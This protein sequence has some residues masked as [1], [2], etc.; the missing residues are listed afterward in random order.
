MCEVRRFDTLN[1]QHESVRVFETQDAAVG[2]CASDLYRY[3][4]SAEGTFRYLSDRQFRGGFNSAS[5]CHTARQFH[6]LV[7]TAIWLRK[8]YGSV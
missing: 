7:T 8:Q 2:C 3:V 4:G 5:K 6:S 1:A